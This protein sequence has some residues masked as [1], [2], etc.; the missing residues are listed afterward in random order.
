MVQ[1][2]TQLFLAVIIFLVLGSFIFFWLLDQQCD[3]CRD[4]RLVKRYQQFKDRQEGQGGQ[5][6]QEGFEKDPFPLPEHHTGPTRMDRIY[7]S[8]DYY[9]SHPF[10]YP[11]P[12]S[13]ETSTFAIKRELNKRGIIY[14]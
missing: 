2:D 12:Y 8:Q 7:D 11:T 3:R 13:F 1:T 6:S 9:H 10:I 4:K 14:E 5:G